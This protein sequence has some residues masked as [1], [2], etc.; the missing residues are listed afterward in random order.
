MV[1]FGLVN[2]GVWLI[3]FEIFR[4]KFI[5]YFRKVRYI[6]EL[7]WL[8]YKNL[9]GWVLMSFFLCGCLVMYRT[10]RRDTQE[11]NQGDDLQTVTES[12]PGRDFRKAGWGFRVLACMTLPAR[13]STEPGFLS[14]GCM[15]R[16]L[17]LLISFLVV[18][19]L[20]KWLLEK[21]PSLSFMQGE[22]GE[23]QVSMLLG[24]RNRKTVKLSQSKDNYQ[25]SEA[26]KCCLGLINVFSVM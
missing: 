20:C 9:I 10:R 18:I 5:K 3:D 25:K 14:P 11:W 24:K 1:S 16:A 13:H 4:I 2:F 15:N 19:Y 8:M 26:W 7:D 6:T 23:G 21:F 22:N 17:L 12:N